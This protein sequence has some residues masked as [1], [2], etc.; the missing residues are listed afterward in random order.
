MIQVSQLFADATKTKIDKVS[1]AEAGLGEFTKFAASLNKLVVEIQAPPEVTI[2]VANAQHD[3]VDVYLE[4]NKV[5][6]AWVI[7]ME[8]G[9]DPPYPEDFDDV[10]EYRR[11]PGIVQVVEKKVPKKKEVEFNIFGLKPKTIYNIYAC[12]QHDKSLEQN[13][14][15]RMTD[16]MI[17]D[18]HE[19][20]VT[21]DEPPEVL[22]IEWSVLT[23]EMQ[24]VEA[25]AAI[26]DGAVQETAKIDGLTLPSVEDINHRHTSIKTSPHLKKWQEF[27]SWWTD[28]DLQYG[29]S[30]VRSDFLFREALYASRDG[31]TIEECEEA[32]Y[33]TFDESKLLTSLVVHDDVK[34]FSD[35]S[36]YIRFRSWFKAG[37]VVERQLYADPKHEKVDEG[38]ITK[39]KAARLSSRMEY[40]KERIATVEKCIEF[41]GTVIDEHKSL[42]KKNL[43]INDLEKKRG[44]LKPEDVTSIMASK[45]L[46]DL[47]ALYK[48][49]IN[50]IRP[51]QWQ[52]LTGI[53]TFVNID[54][55][56]L[57]ADE[58]PQM[59]ML[60]LP[61][62]DKR[63]L[64]AWAFCSE[65][66]KDIEV[67]LACMISSVIELAVE[68]GICVPDIEDINLIHDSAFMPLKY[69]RFQNFK[70]WYCGK[71][72]T[73]SKPTEAIPSLQR[74]LFA[75]WEKSAVYSDASMVDELMGAGNYG[76]KDLFTA[77]ANK[78]E[79]E[80]NAPRGLTLRA[81]FL[82][83]M[84]KQI[85]ISRRTSMQ[86]LLWPSCGPGRM[87]SQYLFPRMGIVTPQ[88]EEPAMRFNPYPSTKKESYTVKE[89]LAWYTAADLINEDKAMLR[90]E[91]EGRRLQEYM[92]WL[93]KEQERRIENRKIMLEEDATSH[94]LRLHVGTISEK[95]P[96]PLGKP[97]NK[98][99]SFGNNLPGR[100]DYLQAT[101]TY[102]DGS[103]INNEDEVAD[104]IDKMRQDAEDAIIAARELKRIAAEERR[105]KDEEERIRQEKLERDQRIE[106]NKERLKRLRAY[107]DNLKLEKKA[108]EEAKAQEAERVKKVLE[109]ETK[110]KTRQ[111]LRQALLAKERN[112]IIREQELM[113]AEDVQQL[114]IRRVLQESS[115][116]EHEDIRG[117]LMREEYNRKAD[118][119]QKRI[120]D[121]ADIY[122]EFQPFQFRKSRVRVPGAH[123]DDENVI[124]DEDDVLQESLREMSSNRSVKW[125]MFLKQQPDAGTYYDNE[126]DAR[127]PL[128]RQHSADVD[129]KKPLALKN[130]LSHDHLIGQPLLWRGPSAQAERR[131]G[132]LRKRERL[133]TPT[134]P[135]AA[136][137]LRDVTSAGI[138]LPNSALEHELHSLGISNTLMKT[139]SRGVTSPKPLTGTSPPR[140]TRKQHSRN[141]TADMNK[142]SPLLTHTSSSVSII[143]K[144]SSSIPPSPLPAPQ[145]PSQ[146]LQDSISSAVLF[147]PEKS[148]LAVDVR[149]ISPSKAE[150]ALL[151]S[152]SKAQNTRR[153]SELAMAS[154]ASIRMQHTA[155]YQRG[156]GKVSEVI[157]KVKDE[158][159]AL[160]DFIAS[161]TLDDD[162]F[163][164][165]ACKP[166]DRDRPYLDTCRDVIEFRK[167][168]HVEGYEVSSDDTIV[169]ELDKDTK[170]DDSGIAAVKEIVETEAGV[171]ERMM[172]DDLRS[173]DRHTVTSAADSDIV[174]M[175]DDNTLIMKYSVSIPEEPAYEGAHDMRQ[176]SLPPPFYRKTFGVVG[177]M[178]HLCAPS[179]VFQA[180]Q[181]SLKDRP[182]N[183]DVEKELTLSLSKSTLKSRHSHELTSIKK[184]VL[185]TKSPSF[186]ATD[187]NFRC[188]ES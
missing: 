56:E 10:E 165:E 30:D 48:V 81:T 74:I 24:A 68:A 107:L 137:L 16:M 170:L 167:S 136:A 85:G 5:A 70:V 127:I 12:A 39:I 174:S 125:K 46:T 13:V 73:A 80:V 17:L 47:C 123:L 97:R 186:S 117:L 49:D 3:M 14:P 111:K 96:T 112:D 77:I 7:V 130:S 23:D 43:S 164:V 69:Q 101:P 11:R 4:S 118:A 99:F 159:K 34:K 145:S 100:Y 148:A 106:E 133:Y 95:P 108:R 83:R 64:K 114:E 146:A 29:F 122:E 88:L 128:M 160:R 44:Q 71:E 172:A 168:L 61:G 124:D 121:L 151:K 91:A 129:F 93:A 66:E 147:Q 141:G 36:L 42:A 176:H 144:L 63:P 92:D 28:D 158:R 131:Y 78:Y 40:L 72:G 113:Y 116:M 41:M 45:K 180:K 105:I 109:E 138:V 142:P 177:E 84:V 163:Y 98:F 119:I 57:M 55:D 33:L 181:S 132:K 60:S 140:T 38:D 185:E 50:A 175:P 139:M 75:D 104:V 126:T 184:M 182:T 20:L 18:T 67:R 25:K 152:M 110:R 162:K 86:R 149:P 79:I 135:D 19:R 8:E 178:K 26:Y 21:P 54:V 134:N 187:V 52:L 173:T 82:K 1:E 166:I 154:L 2:E 35:N 183:G 27:V 155:N 51:S 87:T 94:R 37:R 179:P 103:G 115:S 150:Y 157:R 156:K 102:A 89:I 6:T 153:K 188:E 76:R 171:M 169:E 58:P 62:T 31:V 22:E 53:E 9:V 32:G 90:A 15:S 59:V 161:N 143:N 65:E 120:D